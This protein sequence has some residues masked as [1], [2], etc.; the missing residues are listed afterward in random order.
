MRPPASRGEEGSAPPCR[1]ASINRTQKLEKHLSGQFTQ[2]ETVISM[3][4]ESQQWDLSDNRVTHLFPQQNV[5]LYFSTR[6]GLGPTS[7]EKVLI[8]RTKK[9]ENDLSGQFKQDGTVISMSIESRQRHLCRSRVIHLFPKQNK[10][11]CNARPR[12]G[13]TS[14]NKDKL[15]WNLH[16]FWFAI[17]SLCIFWCRGPHEGGG[18]VTQGLEALGLKSWKKGCPYWYS[19]SLLQFDF[20]FSRNY[21]EGY[22][23][24]WDD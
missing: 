11:H 18:A 8:I 23:I 19:D 7:A 1:K 10:N 24:Y 3:S 13:S 12:N 21:W 6:P 14:Q 15:V 16:R 17:T 20:S 22:S 4:I 9:I 2:D 5:P